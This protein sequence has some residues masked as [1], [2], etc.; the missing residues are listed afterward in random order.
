MRE[1]LWNYVTLA[2][3]CHYIRTT[4]I[5]MF[6]HFYHNVLS[7]LVF[8]DIRLPWVPKSVLSQPR[9]DNGFDL[10]QWCESC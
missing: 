7:T 8:L 10:W 5:Q 4:L 6:L 9:M 1:H 2:K 3:N